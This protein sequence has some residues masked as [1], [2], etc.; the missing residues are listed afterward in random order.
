[1]DAPRCASLR[2]ERV[3]APFPSFVPSPEVLAPTCPFG[4]FFSVPS[5]L[6][7]PCGRAERACALQR[8]KSCDPDSPA[9]DGLRSVVLLVV[10]LLARCS[11]WPRRRKT[12]PPRSATSRA[13]CA[14]TKRSSSLNNSRTPRA[15]SSI[16]TIWPRSWRTPRKPGRS[17]KTRPCFPSTLPAIP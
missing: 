16:T 17:N 11:R 12:T 8:P 1:M 15:L 6:N 14:R 7:F 2:S 3:H 13:T 5:R 9:C 4:N 10:P